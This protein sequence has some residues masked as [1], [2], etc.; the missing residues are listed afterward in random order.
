ML[1]K[2]SRTRLAAH[3]KKSAEQ[4]NRDFVLTM[5]V[6]IGASEGLIELDEKHRKLL[7]KFEIVLNRFKF[8]N[9]LDFD[10]A[11]EIRRQLADNNSFHL[12]KKYWLNKERPS[13]ADIEN[14]LII[15]CNAAATGHRNEE[16]ASIR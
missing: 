12:L 10:I 13:W 4:Y 9:G 15:A 14:A 1:S 2:N 5:F 3:K 6:R 11:R 8:L 16:S 7:P